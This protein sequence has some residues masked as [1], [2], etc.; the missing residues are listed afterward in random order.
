MSSDL[1]QLSDLYASGA[2][3]EQ[4]FTSAKT[5]L[6]RA[7]APVSAPQP[8][9]APPPSGSGY[10]APPSN[11]QVAPAATPS[12]T[13][14]HL[15]PYYQSCFGRF[16]AQGGG[17]TTSWNWAAFFFGC[18]WYLIKGMWAK[19]IIFFVIIAISGGLLAIPAW[20]YFGLG[21]NYDYY[22]LKR[23]QKQLW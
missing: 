17:F 11:R 12:T 8:Y 15:P 22:L 16:E 19:A 10:T 9:V 20:I 2:L 18:L 1:A 3:S 6:L 5:Q 13:F 21:A 23:H 4:E 14:G 7:S